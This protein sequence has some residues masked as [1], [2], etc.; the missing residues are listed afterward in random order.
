MIAKLNALFSGDGMLDESFG[1]TLNWDSSVIWGC[2][3]IPVSQRFQK[4]SLYQLIKMHLSDFS[5]CQ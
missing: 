5:S 4:T 2:Q 1:T 3:L